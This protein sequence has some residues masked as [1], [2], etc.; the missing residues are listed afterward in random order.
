MEKTNTI[1]LNELLKQHKDYNISYNEIDVINPPKNITVKTPE[2][3]I[4]FINENIYTIDLLVI[5][6]VTLDIDKIIVKFNK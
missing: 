1:T 4:R 6:D 5:N 3:V 2:E